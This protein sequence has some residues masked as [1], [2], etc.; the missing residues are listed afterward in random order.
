M[1]NQSIS[2]FFL[3]GMAFSADT[4]KKLGTLE[5][6]VENG[7]G[8]YAPDLLAL[9]SLVARGQDVVRQQSFLSLSL[10]CLN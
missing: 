2:L 4:W 1:K 6:M 10:I 3:H 9:V 5:T 7:S 8:V